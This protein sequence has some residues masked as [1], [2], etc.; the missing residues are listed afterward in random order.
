[1]TVPSSAP[2]GFRLLVACSRARLAPRNAATLDEL[3]GLPL[4]WDEV[5]A[6][7][8]RHGVTPLVHRHLSGR[9][10]VPAA[11]LAE[12]GTYARRNAVH[13]LLLSK[14]LL[15]V[16]G[17]LE[18]AGVRAVPYKGPTLAV[19]AYGDVA[20]RSFQDLDVI[21]RPNEFEPALDALQTSSYALVESAEGRF[22]ATLKHEATG[23]L[24]ELHRDV[25][26]RERF[27]TGLE[28]A[29][30]WESLTEVGLLGQKVPSFAPEDTLLLL[31]LH[32]AKH[33]WQGLVWLCDLAEYLRA[34]PSLDWDRV[35][36]QAERARVT[37][38]LLLG[39]ALAEHVLAAPLPETVQCLVK[40]DRSLP[41]LQAAII[42]RF[43]ED[44]NLLERGALPYRLRAGMRSRLGDKLPVYKSFAARLLR[45][46]EQDK[47]VVKLPKRLEPLYYLVR[48]LRL[49]KDG[50]AQKR[51]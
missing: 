16:L 18:G 51:R 5:L 24:L 22:H 19:A 20:L 43:Y 34:H 17:K 45:P 4:D 38:V 6:E 15:R 48:P 28:L 9:A 12:L 49:L 8:R 21:V 25:V 32:G 23:V 39:L 10:E 47:Q 50:V 41:G 30:M 37:R 35:L 44:A 13:N 3:L 1:M 14:E 42:V 33:E 31:C 26:R 11:P 40:G 46:N 7:A 29:A 2:A 27:P 36:Q